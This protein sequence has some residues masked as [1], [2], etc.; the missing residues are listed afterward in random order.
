VLMRAQQPHIVS[1][2]GV[3]CDDPGSFTILMDLAPKGSLRN[4]LDDAASSRD[5]T[6]SPAVQHAIARGIVSGMAWCHAQTPQPVLHH[7][8][9]SASV[10]L[11]PCKGQNGLLPKITDFGL[12][13]NTTV[14]G[15]TSLAGNSA[16]GSLVN[17]APEAF[18]NAYIA[19]S[20]VYSF[21]IIL[22]ELLTGDMPWVGETE[23]SLLKAVLIDKRR[24]QL[25]ASRAKSFLGG[26]MRRSWAHEHARRPSFEHLQRELQAAA[27]QSLDL[28]CFVCVP[29]VGPL[30]QALDEAREIKGEIEMEGEIGGGRCEIVSQDATA[31][32]LLSSSPMRRFLFSGHCDAPWD[33]ADDAFRGAL[34]FTKSGGGTVAVEP[35]T[36]T[37]IL[38][39]H[40]PA[41]VRF[42]NR[43]TCL[44]LMRYLVRYCLPSHPPSPHLTGR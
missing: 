42:R 9:K 38:D 23:A 43:Y 37:S 44:L 17:K 36:L 5:I 32:R 20:E 13:S 30:Q 12:A 41:N 7:D 8:L 25:S 14:L 11:F 3:V 39:S 4:V 26:L 18:K 22:W 19:A 31:E 21:G 27:Q 33:R 6:S 34:A 40:S 28:L 2:L 15:Q 16:C 29:R 10:L 1:L 24:P 35:A